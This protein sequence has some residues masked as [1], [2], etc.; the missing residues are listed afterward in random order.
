MMGRVALTLTTF[1]LLGCASAPHTKP[2]NA[3]TAAPPPLEALGVAQ[4]E[5]SL[6]ERIAADLRRRHL[7][8][9]VRRQRG[10][11]VV[12]LDWKGHEKP[13]FR[14]LIDT[15]VSAGQGKGLARER[16]V[17]VRLLTRVR[18]P[19]ARRDAVFE[20]LN[21]RNAEY[22]AGT[23]YVHPK[24]GEI[25]GRWALNIPAGETLRT[26]FVFD[27]VVRL[28]SVW[29]DLYPLLAPAMLPRRDV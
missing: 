20:V 4:D 14:M 2:S 28:V 17:I 16:V 27:A 5:H 8:A 3:S 19:S 9:E 24:D 21:R 6:E 25:E 13:D 15:Q 12:V 26:G 22:W 23:F 11:A 29:G 18:V 7:S 1:G 10:D